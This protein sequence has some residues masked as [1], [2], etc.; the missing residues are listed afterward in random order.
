MPI[1]TSRQL[2]QQPPTWSALIIVLLVTA[3]AAALGSI[4]SVTAPDFYAQLIKPVWAP[5]AG[6][7]G[8]VW[9]ALYLMMALSAWLVVSQLGWQSSRLELTVYF[10]QLALNALWSWLFF[11]WRVGTAALVDIALL[12][13]AIIYTMVLFRRVRQGAALLLVPYLLWVSFAAA[14]T[15][16][17]VRLN[18]QLL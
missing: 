11:Y 12:W 8:P 10:V 2:K 1:A 18:P 15:W 4:A 6:V 13:L 14:L 7:F 9:T 16:S 17:V 5:P 3:A